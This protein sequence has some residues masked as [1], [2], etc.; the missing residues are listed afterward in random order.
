MD[1]Q[2]AMHVEMKLLVGEQCELFIPEMLKLQKSDYIEECRD[3][4]KF[5]DYFLMN[6]ILEGCMRSQH[7]KRKFE[8]IRKEKDTDFP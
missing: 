6:N 2:F 5:V 7:M 3:H 4:N 8:F 1:A